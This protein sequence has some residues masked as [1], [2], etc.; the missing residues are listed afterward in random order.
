[1]RSAGRKTWEGKETTGKQTFHIFCVLYLNVD[2]SNQPK[3]CA[4]ASPCRIFRY[5]LVVKHRNASL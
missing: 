2:R 5:F 1:M 3:I 4:L